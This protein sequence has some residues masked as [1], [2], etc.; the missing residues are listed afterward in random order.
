MPKIWLFVQKGTEKV[1]F[2]K[3]DAIKKR[4]DTMNGGVP[5]FLS[6][7][8]ER[9]SV[10]RRIYSDWLCMRFLPFTADF[11]IVFSSPYFHIAIFPENRAPLAFP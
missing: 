3:K 5:P 2:I 10:P 7:F 4:R 6:G 11:L 8:F 1:L 9:F